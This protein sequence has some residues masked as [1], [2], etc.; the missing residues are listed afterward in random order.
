MCIVLFTTAHPDYS[1]ILLDN[2][3][4]FILRPTSRP[5]WWTQPATG[6]QVLSARDLQRAEKG[7]WMGVTKDGL[8]AVLT[9]YR[10]VNTNDASHPVHGIKSRGGMV[11]AWLAGSG[12]SDSVKDG[13][14]HLV[15]DGGVKGVGGFSMVCGKLRRNN[16]SIAIVS[17]R[18]EHADEVP[19]VGHTRGETWGLSNTTFDAEPPWPKVELGREL[20]RAAVQAAVDK[21]TKKKRQQKKQNGEEEEEAEEEEE[22]EDD[23][24]ENDL[25]NSFFDVLDTNTFPATHADMP[26]AQVTGLLRHTIFVPELGDE[27]RKLAMK[28]AQAKGK[29]EWAEDEASLKAVEEILLEQQPEVSAQASNGFEV[30]MYGTQRQT[31]MLVDWQGRVKFVERALWDRNG[32]RIPR[33]EGDVAHEFQIE[34][35]DDE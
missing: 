1:L 10:E 30:G 17:N 21:K 4:E 7:T 27:A 3:D 29:S 32:H 31:V 28:E 14:Q 2:R 16:P 8:F 11:T 34:S 23:F 19:L 15:E 26:F 25:I 20:L 35:W 12:D 24:S 22:E 18:A 13:V 33:G 9:N 6:R 5:H